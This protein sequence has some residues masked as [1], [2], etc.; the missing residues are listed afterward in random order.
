MTTEITTT[1]DVTTKIP[2]PQTDNTENITLIDDNTFISTQES[3]T[4]KEKTSPTTVSRTTYSTTISPV[5]KSSSS[6]PTFPF[7]NDKT[8][9]DTITEQYTN[10]VDIIINPQYTTSGGTI[11]HLAQNQNQSS[12]QGK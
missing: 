4:M 7:V 6:S 5:D 9:M 10:D 11:I 12:N 1:N 2:T 3:S 8:T